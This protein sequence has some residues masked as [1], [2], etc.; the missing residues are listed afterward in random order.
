MKARFFGI[1]TYK[2]KIRMAVNRNKKH[3]ADKKAGQKPNPKKN[4]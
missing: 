3:N 1:W 2:H 4:P